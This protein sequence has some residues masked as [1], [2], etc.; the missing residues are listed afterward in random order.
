MA[1]DPIGESNAAIPP[2]MLIRDELA[3]RS[4][5]QR[6][7]ATA[8]K[9]PVNTINEIVMGRKAVTPRTALGLERVLD[10]PAHI[11]LRLEADYRLALERE[12]A[13]GKPAA[14]SVQ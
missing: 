4:M 5:S 9:R 7:L 8:M 14:A 3:A 12:R 10:V 2:G 1:T 13:E 11:W 6:Q